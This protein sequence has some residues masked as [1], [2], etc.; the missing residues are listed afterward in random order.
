MNTPAPTD[1]LLAELQQASLALEDA[2]PLEILKWAV[3]QYAPNFA[4]ATAFGPEGMT[5]IY[6]L[7]QFSPETPIFNLDTG[8]QFQ[9]TLDLRDKVKS[10]YGMDVRLV[11][12]KLNVAQYEE[13]NGGPVYKSNPS[14]CC[15]DRKL[16]LLEQIASGL[17]CWSS[18]IRRDQSP[19]RAKAPI[20]GWD[21]KFGLIKVSPLANSTKADICLLYTSPSPRDATLSRMPS[22]A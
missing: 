13:F 21:N 4:M 8:Y 18:A 7:S 2:S 11:K 6:M 12:P 15:Y 5:M 19:D 16:S 3:A 1:T 14:Q 10:R 22:S 20:V 17:Q 9:E